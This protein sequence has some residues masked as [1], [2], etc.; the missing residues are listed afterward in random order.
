VRGY[1]GGIKIADDAHPHTT[2]R[3]PPP[4]LGR[5]FSCPTQQETAMANRRVQLGVN[6]SPK[7]ANLVHHA[8][9]G[10][11]ETLSTFVRSALIRRLEQD[12]LDVKAALL[13]A[14]DEAA[15]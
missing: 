4:G 9:R 12:G 8:A 3:Q 10:R 14:H 2:V 15:A 5:V 11:D 6:V 7:L 1:V 13:A